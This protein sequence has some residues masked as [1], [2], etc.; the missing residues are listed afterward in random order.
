MK[1]LIT[2]LLFVFTIVNIQAQLYIEFNSGYAKGINNKKYFEKENS[3]TNKDY[4]N[5]DTSNYSQYNLAQGFFVE[6][7]V[8]YKINNWLSASV[9][10]YYNN[11]SK[12]NAYA[13][14]IKHFDNDEYIDMIYVSDSGQNASLNHSC[15]STSFSSKTISINPEVSFNKQIKNFNIKLNLGV[16]IYSTNIFCTIDTNK[17]NYN[18]SLILTVDSLYEPEVKTVV[19]KTH[20]FNYY[21]N[22]NVAFRVGLEFNYLI[23]NNFS[24]LAKMYFNN[25]EFIPNKREQFYYSKEVVFQDKDNILSSYTELDEVVKQETIDGDLFGMN[26]LQ[27]SFGIRYIFNKKNQE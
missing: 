11:N 25:I 27:F 9:G 2:I 19:T 13:N 16:S 1:K 21:N 18:S 17:T 23:N 4:Y 10:I 22:Y 12:W 7:R 5:L 8:G 20:K 24:I 26:T 6:P 3:Y 14:T 15:F